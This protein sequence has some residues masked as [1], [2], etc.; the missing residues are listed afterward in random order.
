MVVKV[1]PTNEGLTRRQRRVALHLQKRTT[2]TQ[3]PEEREVAEPSLGQRAA[4]AVAAFGGSWRFVALFASVLLLWIGVNVALLA[5]HGTSF[6]PYPFI[7]LNLVLSMLAAIQAPFILMS[8]NRQAEKDRDQA[9]HDY[10]INL[11]AEMEILLLHDKLDQ[12]REGQ[13]R[14]LLALQQ[15]QLDLL[16]RL[17]TSGGDP[18]QVRLRDHV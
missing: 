10:E 18:S 12:L 3:S 5:V 13:W 11:K 17:V 1:Q 6:D 4:D 8:Q 9:G 2:I 7:L 15:E 14:E 16:R